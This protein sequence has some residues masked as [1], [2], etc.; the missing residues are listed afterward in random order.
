MNRDFSVSVE[1]I[2]GDYLDRMSVQLKGM[3][4]ADQQELLDEIRS[5]IFESYSDDPTGD[6]IE[7]ILKVLRKLGE[8]ADVISRRMP[9]DF[10]RV[11]RGRK[12]P[13]YVVAGVLVALVGVPL[14]LGAVAALVGLLASMLGLLVGYFG[15]A[16]SLVVAGFAAATVCGIAVLDPEVLYRI[17]QMAGTDVFQFG[18]FQQNPAL[19]G[20]VGLVF[21]LVLVA[22]GLLM[23][24]GGV[25]LWRGFRFVVVLIV[26]KIRSA[27]TRLTVPKSRPVRI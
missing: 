19:G 10:S 13:L 14:G 3:P 20:L 4:R 12:A 15:A 16:V 17:N 22:V 26:Q 8:P 24:W 7:R 5:H 1:K 27:F 9:S 21:S 11:G 18:P 23:L 2:V 25:H 6:E